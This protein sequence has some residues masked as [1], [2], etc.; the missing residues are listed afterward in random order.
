MAGEKTRFRNGQGREYSADRGFWAR[1]LLLAHE[2][3]WRPEL[4]RMSYLVPDTVISAED[5]HNMRRAFDRLFE[6][7]LRDPARVFPIPV[8]IGELD[9]LRDFVAGGEFGVAD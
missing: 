3:G 1:A 8:D 7:A 9:R 4:L 2:Y 5:A 6:L